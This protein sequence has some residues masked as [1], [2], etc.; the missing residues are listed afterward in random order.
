MV[1]PK[2]FLFGAQSSD[3]SLCQPESIRKW[4][5]TEIGMSQET[6]KPTIAFSEWFPLFTPRTIQGIRRELFINI[7]GP[8]KWINGT[9]EYPETK[10]PRQEILS[11][12]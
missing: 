10:V 1:S 8:G 3:F 12:T 11:I 9:L 6:R 2:D 4:T 5:L 7:Q